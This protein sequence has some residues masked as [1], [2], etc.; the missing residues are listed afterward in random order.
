MVKGRKANVF[1][2]GDIVLTS[3]NPTLGHELRG[4]FRPALVLTKYEFNA[5]GLTLIAPITI[6]GDYSRMAGFTVSLIGSGL[7]TSGV[8]LANSIRTLDL[9]ARPTKKIERAPDDIVNEVL[10]IVGAL[11]E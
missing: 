3:L 7:K 9:T 6:G 11:V 5:L 1:D 8:V 10:L 2:R 4:E